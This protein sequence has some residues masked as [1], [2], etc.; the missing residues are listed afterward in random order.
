MSSSTDTNGDLICI[1][2]IYS[3]WSAWSYLL[4]PALITMYDLRAL[5]FYSCN[6]FSYKPSISNI[7]QTG[8]YPFI[9]GILLSIYSFSL[10]SLNG[11]LGTFNQSIGSHL[12]FISFYAI[13]I[14]LT[15][16]IWT[17]FICQYRAY[18]Y[19]HGYN[20]ISANIQ[21]NKDIKT[22]KSIL[23][24]AKYQCILILVALI[25][26]ICLYSLCNIYG[27]VVQFI[28]SH[29]IYGTFVILLIVLEYMIR[30]EFN[31]NAK[32]E[33]IRA[34]IKLSKTKFIYRIVVKMKNKRLIIGICFYFVSVIAFLCEMFLRKYKCTAYILYNLST[35][36]ALTFWYCSVFGEEWLFKLN[37]NEDYVA[38]NKRLS[39]HVELCQIGENETFSPNQTKLQISINQQQSSLSSMNELGGGNALTSRDRS[40]GMLS[41]LDSPS[42]LIDDDH[43]FHTAQSTPAFTLSIPS[44][45][46]VS[47]ETALISMTDDVEISFNSVRL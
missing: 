15:I 39:T 10:F 31:I 47:Q 41:P 37:V 17:R 19:Y 30:C 25:S 6:C 45:I 22:I 38:E 42:S 26:S 46:S 21:I 33:M 44:R 20:Q 40:V 34:E 36:I 7:F 43:S 16:I 23:F 32:E 4:L 8:I 5:Y 3:S 9:I 35:S 18:Q 27:D 14:I 1:E 12:H 24:S 11:Y 28:A 29:C 2:H 13:C